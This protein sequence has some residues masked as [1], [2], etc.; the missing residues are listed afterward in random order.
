MNFMITMADIAKQA[1]VSRS[2]AS[3]VLSGGHMASR[4]S[5]A[6]RQ[7]V[8]VAAQEM[9]YRPNG[10]AR[11][12]AAGKNYVLG[13]LKAGMLEQDARIIDGVLEGAAEAGYL[14]KMLSRGLE[15]HYREVARH[16][17]EQRLAG[18]IV[19]RCDRRL[20]EHAQ[21]DLIALCEELHACHIPVVFV[22]DDLTLPQGSCVTSDDAQGVQ[23]AMEHLIGL[24]HRQII[25]IAGDIRSP[26]PLFRR[27]CYQRIMREHNLPIPEGAILDC[28]WDNDLLDRLTREL[29]QNGSSWPTALLCD[30]DVLAA[31]AVRAIW[32]I[33]LRVPEDVSVVGYGG[34]SIA[35]Y[36]HPPLTTIAQPF[37]DMGRIAVNHLMR[38][39]ADKADKQNTTQTQG[40]E[41]LPTRLVMGESTAPVHF[42]GFKNETCRVQG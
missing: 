6:T 30:G 18:L 7:R 25:F 13:Y 15:N 20:N 35:P 10:L 29:F 41:L 42:A 8:L 17:V 11:A 28:D 16:S 37:E 33:G 38:R 9:G 32:R 36:L 23:L 31:V 5:A 22:D 2:T 39:I 19:R 21:A 1:G 24:G 4:I 14:V 26:Q 40:P 34:F 27:N 12:V 3:F